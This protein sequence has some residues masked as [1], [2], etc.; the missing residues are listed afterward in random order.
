M[1]A[2]IIEQQ[3]ITNMQFQNHDNDI[4][5]SLAKIDLTDVI[6]V[7]KQTAYATEIS[8]YQSHFCTALNPNVN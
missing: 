2:Y 3:C 7:A 6:F 5:Q 4:S 8:V 1:A